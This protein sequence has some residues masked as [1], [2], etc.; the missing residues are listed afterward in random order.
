MLWVKA[1]KLIGS[2]AKTQRKPRDFCRHGRCT[3]HDRRQ[4]LLTDKLGTL[5]TPDEVL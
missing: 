5:N 4:V 1:L 3:K 2:P